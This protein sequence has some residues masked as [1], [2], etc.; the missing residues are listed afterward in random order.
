MPGQPEVGSVRRSAERI[1]ANMSTQG[2][3]ALTIQYWGFG[4]SRSR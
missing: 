1:D 4:G 2:V 3:D